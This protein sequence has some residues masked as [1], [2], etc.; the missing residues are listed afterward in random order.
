VLH[1]FSICVTDALLIHIQDADTPREAWGILCQMYE[2]D[3][4]ARNIQLKQQIHSVTRR[5]RSILM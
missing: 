5:N 3:I 4:G 2:S 1:Y